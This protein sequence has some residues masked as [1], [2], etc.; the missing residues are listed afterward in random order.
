MLIPEEDGKLDGL[1]QYLPATAI[2]EEI[3]GSYPFNLESWV[4]STTP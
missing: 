2:P 4:R 1:F 3:G